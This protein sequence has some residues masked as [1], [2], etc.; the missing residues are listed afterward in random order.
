MTPLSS[1]KMAQ[2][3]AEKV[4]IALKLILVPA[5]CK[6]WAVKAMTFSLSAVEKSELTGVKTKTRYLPIRTAFSRD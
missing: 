5:I 4:T 2:P 6:H 1:R 3:T